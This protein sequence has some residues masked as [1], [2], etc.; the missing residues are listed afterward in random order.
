[1]CIARL[2]AVPLASVFLGAAC[3]EP[4]ERSLTAAPTPQRAG[5]IVIEGETAND[6]GTYS[7]GGSETL[8]MSARDFAFSPT[9]VLG[10]P[11]L[12][13][14]IDLVAEGEGT[15][16]FTLPEEGIDQDVAGGE[17]VRISATF[18][19]TGTFVFFCKYHRERG[20]VGGLTAA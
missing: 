4:P 14:E 15:H 16:S 5:T 11:D 12:A 19:D 8:E 7:V 3:S 10:P 6:A 20:M 1:M 17:T 13:I 2:L 18:P 9:L